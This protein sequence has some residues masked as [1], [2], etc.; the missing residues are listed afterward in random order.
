MLRSPSELVIGAPG[1]E[2]RLGG[3]GRSCK[4]REVWARAVGASNLSPIDD[5]RRASAEYYVRCVIKR[6]IAP[7]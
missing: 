6:A 7:G 1:A 3:N 2:H 5:A 4:S